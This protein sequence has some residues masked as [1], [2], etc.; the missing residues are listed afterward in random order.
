MGAK[1]RNDAQTHEQNFSVGLQE[2][3][4]AVLDREPL[5]ALR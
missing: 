2:M 3:D 4:E 1:L 5:V